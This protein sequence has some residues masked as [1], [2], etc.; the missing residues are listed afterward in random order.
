[1]IVT[2]ADFLTPN[3]LPTH[4]CI[5]RFKWLVEQQRASDVSLSSPSPG[6]AVVS[7]YKMATLTHGHLC[8]PLNKG[9][10]TQ[11]PSPDYIPG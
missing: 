7:E 11:S 8:T 2:V 4:W 9:V 3:W 1:M 10:I 6:S 5:S